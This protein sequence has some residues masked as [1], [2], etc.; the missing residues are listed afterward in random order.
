MVRYRIC[1]FLC[2]SIWEGAIQIKCQIRE[3]PNGKFRVTDE[4]GKTVDVDTAY[5]A[6]RYL[7]SDDYG[8][9]PKDQKY[10]KSWH[11][12]D[13]T[14]QDDFCY[15]IEYG[16]DRELETFLL[17]HPQFM[18]LFGIP[19]EAIDDELV[20]NEVMRMGSWKT[21]Q[22]KGLGLLADEN[23]Y[24]KHLKKS[25]I[26]GTVKGWHGK[27]DTYV[28][29]YAHL[30]RRND[31]TKGWWWCTC[32]WGQWCN[33]GHRPHDGPDSWG[34]VKVNNRLCSHAYAMYTLLEKYR[35]DHDDSYRNPK[36]APVLI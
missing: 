11:N 19:I 13:I 28:S 32:E 33:S 34:S 20:R 7:W 6:E 8:D 22:R 2:G 18:E 3:L 14:P 17:L 26:A 25:Y 27:Y 31:W 10:R 5:D 9:L 36:T 4:H 23:V 12:D 24:V 29:R 15:W 16:N 35:L 1:S 21:V 30:D